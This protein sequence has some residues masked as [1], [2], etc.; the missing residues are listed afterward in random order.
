MAISPIVRRREHPLPDVSSKVRPA[1]VEYD[2]D[3]SNS[4]GGLPNL[5]EASEQLCQRLLNGA[6]YRQAGGV[7]EHDRH[8]LYVLVNQRSHRATIVEFAL[9]CQLGDRITLALQVDAGSDYLILERDENCDWTFRQLVIH[10]DPPKGRSD[11]VS[12][13]GLA[14]RLV[15][16]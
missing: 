9:A 4:I 1:E 3:R 8:E 10:V 2:I 6:A 12:L 11:D 15:G 5:S 16:S 13:L 14:P 7:T